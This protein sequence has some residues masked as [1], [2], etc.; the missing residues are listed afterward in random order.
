MS[1]AVTAATPLAAKSRTASSAISIRVSARRRSADPAPFA[2][3]VPGLAP[4]FAGLA[5]AP[6]GSLLLSSNGEGTVLRL[7]PNP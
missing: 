3:G 2:H 7:A 1:S 6:D 4:R 5:A